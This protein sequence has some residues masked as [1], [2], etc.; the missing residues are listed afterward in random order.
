MIIQFSVPLLEIYFG[1][2]WHFTSCFGKENEKKKIPLCNNMKNLI[3][4]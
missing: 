1:F 4:N 3:T 2:K